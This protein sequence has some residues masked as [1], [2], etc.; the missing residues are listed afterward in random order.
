[1]HNILHRCG[2]DEYVVQIYANFWLSKYCREIIYESARKKYIHDL[3][4]R[5]DK[6]EQPSIELIDHPFLCFSF[7]SC[8]LYFN[9][10]V[11]DFCLIFESLL[12]P[13]PILILAPS[14]YSH[15]IFLLILRLQSANILIP[16]ICNIKNSAPFNETN[17]HNSIPVFCELMSV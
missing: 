10:I 3:A 14:A 8:L 9:S 15:I 2:L 7:C 6:L 5:I 12:S 4:N 13:T 1:M 16:K 11:T 17:K